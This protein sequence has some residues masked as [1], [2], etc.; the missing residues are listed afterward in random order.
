MLTSLGTCA[1]TGESRFTGA[2]QWTRDRK[3]AHHAAIQIEYRE[4]DR[5]G[6]RANGGKR[7][8]PRRTH[9]GTAYAVRRD[10]P[11]AGPPSLR[12]RGIAPNGSGRVIRRGKEAAL[13]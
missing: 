4:L 10:H 7:A 12:G 2:R 1:V 9:S 3:P 8:R 11:A 13:K 5:G 6:R